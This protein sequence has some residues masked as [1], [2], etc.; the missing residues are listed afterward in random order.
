MTP[1]AHHKLSPSAS[2]QW[3]TCTPSVVFSAPFK[4]TY[5]PFAAEGVRAHSLGELL[6][7]DKLGIINKP[8]YKKEW[9]R[10][11]AS[12]FYNEAMLNYC[13]DYALFVME[14]YAE[15]QERTPDAQIFL[16]T[17]VDLTEWIEGGFGTVDVQIIADDILEIIDLKY[18]KGVPVS[19]VDNPQ[20]KTYALGSLKGKM[21]LFDIN[22]VRMTIYQPRIDNTDSWEMFVNE[23]LAWGDVVLRPGAA[24][25]MKGE[26]EFVPGDH[27]RF[28]RGAAVCKAFANE[29]L[30]IAQHDFKDPNMMEDEDIA[31]VLA[32]EKMFTT[33]I[34]KVTTYAHDQA[35][36]HGKQWPGFKLVEG[37][38][39]RVYADKE[40]VA[41][42][43]RKAGYTDSEI[44]EMKLRGVTA[45]TKEIGKAEFN[46]LLF[47]HIIKPQGKPVLVPESDKREVFQAL[48]N[49]QSDF[50]EQIPGEGGD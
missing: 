29:S 19:C 10:I 40:V 39:N 15:A 49:A 16:E 45:M 35:V 38:S 33:W 42:T 43:L 26:G 25:A 47:D 31:D 4:E 23:L 36:N 14:R 13:E 37:R 2:K 27:C 11:T 22:T 32:R 21:L 3:L 1:G 34:E 41:A 7:R 17:K 28:C 48:S 18:G 6:I 50:E 46:K 5:S 44:F 24:L 30:K 8:E 9:A 12:E 20:M